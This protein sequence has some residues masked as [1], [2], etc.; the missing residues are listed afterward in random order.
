MERALTEDGIE[1]RIRRALERLGPAFIKAGQLAATRR[2]LVAPALVSELEKRAGNYVAR[3]IEIAER[4][5][6]Q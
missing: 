2:D 1:A 5:Q 3:S 6:T 4:A